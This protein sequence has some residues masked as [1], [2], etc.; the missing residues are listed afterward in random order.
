MK[1]I[2]ISTILVSFLVSIVVLMFSSCTNDDSIKQIE[3]EHDHLREQIEKGDAVSEGAEDKA[4]ALEYAKLFEK[5]ADGAVA[6]KKEYARLLRKFTENSIEF[7][8]NEVFSLA[9]DLSKIYTQMA[10]GNDDFGVQK[11][12]VFED[13]SKKKSLIIDYINVRGYSVRLM[14]ENEKEYSGEYLVEYDGSLGKHRVEISFYDASASEKF[15]EQYSIWNAHKL[16]DVPTDS[17]LALSIKAVYTPDH[18]FVIYLGSDKP[19]NIKE[20]DFTKLDRP[21]GRIEI[22]I[23][24]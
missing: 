6:Q 17:E 14:D 24:E 22:A 16:E 5:I 18:A 21:I 7:N 19:L 23:E 11:I 9:E 20:Q 2:L 4:N 12:K 3:E 1:K 13:S 15:T 8:D 10:E